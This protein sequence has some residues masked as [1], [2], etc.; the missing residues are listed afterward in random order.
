MCICWWLQQIW[1]N[2]FLN[3]RYG[4]FS[5][6]STSG[7]RI[8][9]LSSQN[10][11]LLWH[12]SL[13][14]GVIQVTG[15]WKPAELLIPRETNGHFSN[16][17]LIFLYFTS[18]NI[19]TTMYIFFIKEL[20]PDRWLS[21]EKVNQRLG[22]SNPRPSSWKVVALTARRP[23]VKLEELTFKNLVHF[24]TAADRTDSTVLYDQH[25]PLFVKLLKQ[26]SSSASCK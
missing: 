6:F 9:I 7:L 11:G 22:D 14:P 21:S 1:H 26:F 12:K 4:E 24:R 17:F 25:H 8:L 16:L 10:G 3:P 5:T 23:A 13:H 20:K 18:F 15:F 19:G 2:V